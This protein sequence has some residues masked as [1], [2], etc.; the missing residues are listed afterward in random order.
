MAH[1]FAHGAATVVATLWPLAATSKEAKRLREAF[2]QRG[3][4]L[5]ALFDV[6]DDSLASIRGLR[7]SFAH[8][9]ERYEQFWLDSPSHTG[10]RKM[11][12]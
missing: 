11:A 12:W 9:D 5:R 4:E 2:P 8:I 7:N 1:L 6:R 10:C 3:E